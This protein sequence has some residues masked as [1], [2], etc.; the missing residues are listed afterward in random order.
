MVLHGQFLSLNDLQKYIDKIFEENK[1][2]LYS[3]PT[4]FSKMRSSIGFGDRYQYLKYKPGNDS[5]PPTFYNFSSLFEDNKVKRIGRTFGVSRKAFNSVYF[6]SNLV[7]PKFLIDLPGPG[8]Y[9]YEQTNSQNKKFSMK[10]RHENQNEFN[11]FPSPS[12]YFPQL[13]PYQNEKNMGRVSFGFGKKSD[14]TK[15]II[16]INRFYRL[17]RAWFL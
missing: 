4:I 1:S 5:P 7:S 16:E 11:K 13:N 10:F 12:K 9:L 2:K 6:P 3:F 14:P 8:H 15:I 17:S